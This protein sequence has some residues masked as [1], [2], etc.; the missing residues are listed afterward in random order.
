MPDGSG[1]V[2]VELSARPALARVA[3]LLGSAVAG[4]GDDG[5]RLRAAISEAFAAVAGD[6]GGRVRLTVTP[7]PEGYA[8]SLTARAAPAIALAAAR[9]RLEVLAGVRVDPSG[10]DATVRFT[11]GPQP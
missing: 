9:A 7:G 5:V 3:R 8:V 11:V 10:G 2:V 1:E 6:T 4:D